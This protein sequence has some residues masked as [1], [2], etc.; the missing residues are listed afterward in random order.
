MKKSELIAYLAH[1]EDLPLHV[2]HEVVEIIFR[3]MREELD[4][5]RR[6]ELRGFGTFRSKVYEPY[7]GRNPKTGESVAV[8]GKRLVLFKMGKKLIE[9]INNGHPQ[10]RGG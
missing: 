8:P 4:A 1:A 6:V 7:T 5:D 10:R 2:A 9:R 3:E